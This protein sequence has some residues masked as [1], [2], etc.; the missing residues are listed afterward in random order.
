LVTAK[1]ACPYLLA[2]TLVDERL[3]ERFVAKASF[4]DRHV[5]AF[6]QADTQH[7]FSASL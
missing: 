6:L 7:L 1:I 3:D 2:G 5:A 4:S